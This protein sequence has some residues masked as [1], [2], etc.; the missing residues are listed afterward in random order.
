MFRN[1]KVNITK[2][3]TKTTHWFLSVPWLYKLWA[4]LRAGI[5]ICYSPFA[6]LILFTIKGE[7]IK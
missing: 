7:K 2:I 3:K 6:R 4:N 5:N 1:K